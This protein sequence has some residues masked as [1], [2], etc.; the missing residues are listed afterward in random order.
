MAE[1]KTLRPC[2]EFQQEGREWDRLVVLRKDT[3]GSEAAV[4]HSQIRKDAVE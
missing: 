2:G 3:T 4:G 1:Q